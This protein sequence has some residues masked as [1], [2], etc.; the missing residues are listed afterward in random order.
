MSKEELEKKLAECQSFLKQV[1]AT[2][3]QVQGKITLLKEL[4]KNDIKEDE[5]KC[6]ET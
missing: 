6:L 4:L 3:H 5:P 2:F 1:E